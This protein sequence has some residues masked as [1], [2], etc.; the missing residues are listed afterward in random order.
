MLRKT[1]FKLLNVLQKVKKPNE[2]QAHLNN[3]H[4]QFQHSEPPVC[5]EGKFKTIPIG[6]GYY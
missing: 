1:G 2:T 5:S 6:I 4:F 3:T